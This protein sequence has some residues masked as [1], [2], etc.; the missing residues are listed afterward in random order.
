MWRCQRGHCALIAVLNAP[1]NASNGS[2]DLE[3]SHE[4]SSWRVGAKPRANVRVE[5]MAAYVASEPLDGGDI[6]CVVVRI[7]N[8]G[9]LLGDDARVVTCKR[10]FGSVGCGGPR[11][12]EGDATARTSKGRMQ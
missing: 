11:V 1:E 8:F 2:P 3:R 9:H 6:Q 12:V 10:E 4:A 7:A 5:P